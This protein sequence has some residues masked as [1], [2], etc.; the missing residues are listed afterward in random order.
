MERAQ[1][2]IITTIL[3]ATVS[4]FAYYM[5]IQYESSAQGLDAMI[6]FFDVGQGDAIYIR[7]TTGD[8]V[9]IDGG[10]NDEVVRRLGEA[11]N[12]W[13]RTIE[14]MVLSHPDADHINGLVDLFDYYT[15]EKIMLVDL[16]ID[17][18][19]Q[20]ELMT[21]INEQGT[22]VMFVHS[23]DTYQLGEKEKLKVL[24]PFVDSDFTDLSKNDSSIVLEYIYTG[25]QET[26]VLLTGD[27]SEE[28]EPDLIMAEVLEDID[29]LKAG[30]HGSKYSS[31]NEFLE[32]VKPEVVAIQVGADNSFG[33]PH[34]DA[35]SRFGKYAEIFRTDELGNIT[36]QISDTGY[37]LV[38]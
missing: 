5:E 11:M 15:V 3:V 18:P 38:H 27:L 32:I 30:H 34:P 35:M 16:E 20:E 7:S 37:L 24:Y 21:A 19:A 25:E 8:D 31:T 9:V 6:T 12:F 36:F 26:K 29:I 2:I 23:G 14:L 17:S 28:I 1:K 10:P 33:H 22:D 13:N 4:I